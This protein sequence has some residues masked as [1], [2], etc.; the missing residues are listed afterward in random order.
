MY[1]GGEPRR[2]DRMMEI[3]SRSVR[4]HTHTHMSYDIIC[5]ERMSESMKNTAGEKRVKINNEAE[6]NE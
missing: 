5:P 2:E 4:T 3:Q 6:R 1:L